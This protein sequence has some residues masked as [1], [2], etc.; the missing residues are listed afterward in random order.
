LHAILT[1]VLPIFSLMLLGFL[2]GR[3]GRTSDAGIVGLNRFVYYFAMPPLLFRLMSTLDASV[4]AEAGFVAAYLGAELATV[5]LAGL[6]G[7]LLF[8]RRLAEQAVMGI[9]AGFSNGVILA[10]PLALALGGEAGAAPALVTIALDSLI[11][12]PLTI[13]LVEAGL[14]GA[15]RPPLA[16]AWATL[17]ALAA[18][19]QVLSM[20]LGAAWGASDLALPEI[21]Q[22]TV[23][24]V[25][26]AAAPLSLFAVGATLSR[27]RLA[28]GAVA[29]VGLLV[30]LKLL[31][32]PGLVWL[33]CTRVFQ[34]P[35]D[36]VRTAVVIAA[37]PTGASAYT[38]ARHY[39]VLLGPCASAVL[40]SSALSA[41][42][43]SVLL[44]LL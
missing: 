27:E 7:A 35:D 31:F 43:V 10:L 36:W 4:F 19:P 29:D 28:A 3:F 26:G 34:V 23:N 8:R 20:G 6:A 30:A 5:A 40:V 24:V 1:A 32:M 44:L 38:V 13:V 2:A 22:R 39:N 25:A 9:S 14:G 41:G 11:L 37:M 33:F 42:T 16:A 15:G 21:A 12:F 18:N 17:K